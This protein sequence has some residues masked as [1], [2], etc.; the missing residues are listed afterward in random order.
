MTETGRSSQLT[1]A[2]G[3]NKT[4]DSRTR[5]WLNNGQQTPEQRKGNTTGQAAGDTTAAA[6]QCRAWTS[7][8]FLF[9]CQRQDIFY[10]SFGRSHGAALHRG[11]GAAPRITA[12]LRQH[13]H[14][15]PP[16]APLWLCPETPSHTSDTHTHRH[17]HPREQRCSPNQRQAL[18][19]KRSR[20]DTPYRTAVGKAFMERRHPTKSLE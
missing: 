4:R 16:G 19:G 11:A 1:T 6:A 3:E 5:T 8:T 9:L 20:G 17:T 15:V 10:G 18:S 14:P 7:L 2:K 13:G 12:L